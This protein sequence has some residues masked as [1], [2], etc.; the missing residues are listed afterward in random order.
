MTS[1]DYDYGACLDYTEHQDPQQIDE[2]RWRCEVC[3]TE[4]REG[5]DVDVDAA[6]MRA[7]VRVTIGTAD[8]ELD[9]DTAHL[10]IDKVQDA[11]RRSARGDLH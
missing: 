10:L 3:G 9:T 4:W 6:P 8:F 11:L 2:H 1:N 7:G 5:E